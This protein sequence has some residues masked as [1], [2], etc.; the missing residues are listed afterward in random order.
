MVSILTL[1]PV[2]HFAHDR[3]ITEVV[4]SASGLEW[5]SIVK[6][7]DA[8]EVTWVA[9]CATLLFSILGFYYVYKYCLE[10]SECEFQQSTFTDFYVASH[11][12]MIRNVNPTVGVEESNRIIRKL[13][14]EWFE[15]SDGIIAVETLRCSQKIEALARRRT[16]Y[17]EKLRQIMVENQQSVKRK[18]IS[19]GSYLHCNKKSVDA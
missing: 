12:I 7:A 4:Q 11:S 2:Y 17:Q 5:F 13:M 14:E 16:A 9:I 3:S 18:K 8:P 19:I 15:D 10:M 1:I 6:V